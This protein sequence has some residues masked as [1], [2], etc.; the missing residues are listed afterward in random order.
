MRYLMLICGKPAE[1]EAATAESSEEE[2]N[3]I[4]AWAEKWVSAGKLEVGGELEE[5][6]KAKTIRLDGDGRPVV[7]DGPYMELKE[8]IGGLSYLNA[9]NME[10]AVSI[11]ATFPSLKSFPG[12]SVEVRPIIEH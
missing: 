8:I 7:T 3:E 2:M 10:E 6:A 11:A 9:E 5:P 4:I 1:W 12:N